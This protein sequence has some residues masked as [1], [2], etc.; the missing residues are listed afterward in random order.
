MSYN[1]ECARCFDLEPSII[2]QVMHYISGQFTGQDI[3]IELEELQKADI[4][5]KYAKVDRRPLDPPPV[6]LLRVF[7]VHDKGKDRQWEEEISH[8]EELANMGIMCTVDLFPVPDSALGPSH[9]QSTSD[10]DNLQDQQLTFFPLHPYASTRPRSGF[11]SPFTIPR[12]QSMLCH[13]PPQPLHDAVFRLQ[14]HLVTESSKLTPALVGEKF[15]EPV[16]VDY[17]DKK[18]LMFAFSDLAVQREG[19]FILRYRVFDIFSS[20]LPNMQRPIQAELYGGS[21][22][23]YSTREFPG[24]PASTELTKR[25]SKYG[26]RLALRDT[27]R[28]SNKRGRHSAQ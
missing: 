28:I 10:T 17:K 21:F 24:L 26:V 8:Y 19:T 11:I 9:N 15:V 2:G 23:V 13:V 12:G 25:L 3:R 6:V 1:N 22:K 27:E 18:A 16:L 20:V 4:G 5:R 14:N 7:R